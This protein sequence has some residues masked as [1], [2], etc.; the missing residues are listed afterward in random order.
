VDFVVAGFGVGAI[1]MLLGFAV[2][3]LGPLRYRS[4]EQLTP[5]HDEWLAM[6]RSVGTVLIVGG[7]VVCLA[8]LVSLLIGVGD[9]TG[10]RLVM[11]I[12][13]IAVI[14]CGIWSVLSIRRFVA[15]QS[16]IAVSSYGSYGPFSPGTATRFHP[17]SRHRANPQSVVESFSTDELVPGDEVVA[18]SDTDAIMGQG[19][20]D[21]DSEVVS[22]PRNVSSPEMNAPEPVVPVTEAP[23][24]QPPRAADRPQGSEGSTTP[25]PTTRSPEESSDSGSERRFSSRL[26][27]DVEDERDEPTE[28][29]RSTL[30]AE[31]DGAPTTPR[32]SGFA[33]SIFADLGH[34]AN[35]SD[36]RDEDQTASAQDHD[37]PHDHN[38]DTETTATT[39]EPEGNDEVTATQ[40]ASASGTEL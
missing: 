14:G 16:E 33:S 36:V 1:L 9:K 34:S 30:L 17:R 31:L 11:A 40:P 15:M 5:V 26:L 2:R 12:V 8:T 21:E 37:D 4:V 29:F 13:A 20:S 27:A 23:G 7:I 24:E 25:P 10:S 19:F 38:P 39:R 32:G 6:C 22:P 18:K 35:G 28:G 3:D